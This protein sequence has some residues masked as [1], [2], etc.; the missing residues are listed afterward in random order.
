[1]GLAERVSPATAREANPCRDAVVEW[2]CRSALQRLGFAT[3]REIAGFWA[4]VSA[5][6]AQAWCT[7]HLG[8]GVEQVTVECADG[9]PS[10]PLFARGDLVALL[11]DLPHPPTH[12]RFLSPFDPLIRDRLRTHRMFNFD[13]RIEVFVPAVQRRYG[14]YVLPI[15]Q[16]D[17]L[18]CR[19]PMTN[20]RQAGTL[21]LLG[22]WLEPGQRLTGGRQQALETALE[23]L[24]QFIGADAIVFA[25][26]YLK[27]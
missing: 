20:R 15:L 27:S 12:L 19:I 10:R 2:A 14:Y 11:K 9:A 4:V 6:E 8:D 5:A 24:R 26:G 21:D 1:D 7:H 25:N 22:L 18:I 17:R 16:G 3:A 23:R 13:Y